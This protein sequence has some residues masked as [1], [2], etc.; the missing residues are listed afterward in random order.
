MKFL[1]FVFGFLSEKNSYL[2]NSLTNGK[3]NNRQL[4]TWQN[5]WVGL[6]RQSQGS[7]GLKR[8]QSRTQGLPKG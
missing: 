1:I 5:P 8:Q 7:M 3:S 2:Y 4:R 6:Q